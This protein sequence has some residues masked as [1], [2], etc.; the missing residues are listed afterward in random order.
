MRTRDGPGARGP[1]AQRA[2]LGDH[3]AR[4]RGNRPGPDLI[5]ATIV[6]AHLNSGFFSRIPVE[7]PLLEE[8]KENAPPGA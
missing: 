3:R 4:A 7:C 8:H 1:P 2:L 5:A 6:R